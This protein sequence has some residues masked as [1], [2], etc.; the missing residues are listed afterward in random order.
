MIL[1]LSKV[2]WPG[3]IVAGRV[4]RQLNGLIP[5]D[6]IQKSA[7]ACQALVMSPTPL[8]T[9]VGVAWVRPAIGVPRHIPA[10]VLR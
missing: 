4:D 9:E 1:T 10:V 3:H 5:P 6:S 8:M 7:P 2:L